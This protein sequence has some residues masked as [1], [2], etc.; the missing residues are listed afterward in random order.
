MSIER[1]NGSSI[2]RN[3][4]FDWNRDRLMQRRNRRR[5]LLNFHVDVS[6][7]VAV[8][9]RRSSILEINSSDASLPAVI[10][11]SL[12]H[13]RRRTL[14]AAE[15]IAAALARS[16]CVS[17]SAAEN[18]LR[19]PCVNAD[20]SA[21]HELRTGFCGIGKHRQLSIFIARMTSVQKTL[22]SS[23]SIHFERV[24]SKNPA[25]SFRTASP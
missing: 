18:K 6:G 11:T 12:T 16:K 3:A 22:V 14:I 7:R 24:S 15:Q 8:T 2:T 1:P 9:P 5:R 19:S 21:S 17:I 13:V 20:S 10:S 25:R 23:Q 4:S